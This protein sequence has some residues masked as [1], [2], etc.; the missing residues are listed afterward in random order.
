MKN[1][2]KWLNYIRLSLESQWQQP[3]FIMYLL[4]P[5]NLLFLPFAYYN[6]AKYSKS[7]K[8]IL[9]GNAIAGGSGKTPIVLEL[10]KKFLANNL[11]VALVLRGYPLKLGSPINV[12]IDDPSISGDE[13]CMILRELVEFD[14][15]QFTIYISGNYRS[16]LLAEINDKYDIIISDDGFQTRGVY[17][18]TLIMLSNPCANKLLLPL[19]PA[20]TPEFLYRKK[21]NYVIDPNKLN[22]Y[23]DKVIHVCGKEKNNNVNFNDKNIKIITAIARPTRFI[24]SL[25]SFVE[26]STYLGIT[27]E[28]YPDHYDLTEVINSYAQENNLVIVIPNKNYNKKMQHPNLAITSEI[29]ILP[30]EL[31]EVLS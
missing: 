24:N 1:L 7:S 2:L 28:F 16:R 18:R 25:K 9:V 23:I 31:Y 3:N 15:K 19:G 5:I 6:R 20:R 30:D 8:V 22:R 27:H 17:Y 21:A 14:K 11:K 26:S 10:A 13:A 29:V 4:T 12:E